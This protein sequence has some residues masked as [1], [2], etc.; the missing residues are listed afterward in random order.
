LV[1]DRDTLIKR[2]S[3]FDGPSI[4]GQVVEVIKDDFSGILF[5]DGVNFM[6][7]GAA[8]DLG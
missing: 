6:T 2:V 1:L 5:D 3:E 4:A 8:K 7:G